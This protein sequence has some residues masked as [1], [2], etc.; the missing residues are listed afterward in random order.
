[1]RAMSLGSSETCTSDL[2]S[3]YASRSRAAWLIGTASS[4]SSDARVSEQE[5]PAPNAW[6]YLAWS[7]LVGELPAF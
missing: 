2:G 5:I 4:A 6:G 3:T 1:M 7:R